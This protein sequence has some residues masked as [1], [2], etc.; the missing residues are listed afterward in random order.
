MKLEGGG[1]EVADTLDRDRLR[2]GVWMLMVVFLFSGGMYNSIKL[3]I[4][5][6]QQ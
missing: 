1:V 4:S 5:T 3:L 6:E 2:L